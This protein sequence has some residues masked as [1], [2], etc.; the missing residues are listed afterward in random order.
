MEFI[1]HG[2][3]IIKQLNEAGAQGRWGTGDSVRERGREGNACA[4]W[5]SS[6]ATAVRERRLSAR[7]APFP[8][9][10]PHA[11]Y[12]LGENTCATVT[13][14]I[15]RLLDSQSAVYGVEKFWIMWKLY[16]KKVRWSY[17]N[18]SKLI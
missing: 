13:A 18:F 12:S 8:R 3:Q 1:Q 5:P 2:T 4:D 14:F 9:D 16:N 17:V 6:C 10:P 11:E 15:P 7:L